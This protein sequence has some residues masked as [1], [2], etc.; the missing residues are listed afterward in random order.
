MIGFEIR[1]FVGI[2]ASLLLAVALCAASMLCLPRQE[3]Y[4]ADGST[5]AIAIAYDNSGSMVTNSDKWCGAKYSLEVLAAMLDSGDQ[6]ALYAMDNETLKLSLT[7]SQGS[8]QCVSAVHSADLG[9]SDWTDPRAAQLAYEHLKGVSADEKYL[10]ITTD[11]A[12]NKGGRLS[13]IQDVVAACSADGIK[14]VYLAIGEDA[15]LIQGN[16]EAGVYAMQASTDTILATMTDVANL[17]FG[18]DALPSSALGSGSLSLEIPMSKIIV[19]AQGENVQVGDLV[20]PDGNTVSGESAQVRYSERP[21]ASTKYDPFVVDESLQG[22]VSSFAAEMPAGEYSIDIQGASSVEVY[23]APYVG[24]AMDLVDDHGIEYDLE[25]GSENELSAGSYLATYTFLDPFTGEEIDSDLLYPAT[26]ATTLETGDGES[27]FGEE[28]QIVI[29]KGTVNITA[30]AETTGG[31]RVTQSYYGIEVQP[32]LNFLDVDASEVPE[33]LPVNEFE[34]SK[35]LVKVSKS[36]GA[37]ISAEEWSAL[38]FTVEDETGI[39]WNVEKTSEVGVVSVQPTYMEGG[40]WATQKQLCGTLAFLPKTADLSLDATIDCGNLVYKGAADEKVSY[41]PDILS[42]ILHTWPFLLLLLLLLYLIYKYVTKPRLPRKMKPHLQ[43]GD[44]DVPLKYNEKN[45]QNK[46]SPWGPERIKFSIIPK[47]P[48][49]VSF[50]NFP[51]RFRWS[52][53]GLVAAKKKNG[54]RQFVFDDETLSAMRAHRDNPGNYPDPEY[55]VT[56]PAAEPKDDG[57]AGAKGKTKRKKKSNRKQSTMGATRVITF[58][59]YKA[60]QPGKRP[61]PEYYTLRFK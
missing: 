2:C 12:F 51:A 9:V 21:S 48:N 52:T 13:A 38:E 27:V 4:A 33:A 60:K 53:V 23:Y 14:V 47:V 30:S 31:V 15:E 37:A 25:P 50:Y 1:R 32:E 49:E 29:P 10:V 3:A 42:T 44:E 6:L 39:V 59:G 24:I 55:S 43:F 5:R 46:Y 20:T 56:L 54:K 8:A 57:N 22:V 61:K 18:R 7:G 36:D 40:A 11:G 45:I 26:F 28:D 41:T 35:Y 19:F 58:T 17:V 34:D 16:P